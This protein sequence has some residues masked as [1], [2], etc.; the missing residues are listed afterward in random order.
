MKEL[1]K[2]KEIDMR[3]I[4][5]HEQYD[6]SPWIE[7]NIYKI[8]ELLNLQIEIEKREESIEKFRL[9]LSGIESYSQVPVVIENQYN[10]SDHAHLG[11]LITYSAHKEAGI[12]IWI[13]NQFHKAHINAINWLNT[14]SPEEMLF[15]AVQLKVIQI[16]N[17]K[18]APLFNIAV[19]PPSY[20]MRLYES[21]ELSDRQKGYLSFFENLKEKINQTYPNIQVYKP[22]PRNYIHINIGKNI[23]SG[24]HI[25]VSFGRGNIFRVEIYID[26]GN[27]EDNDGLFTELFNSKDEIEE[28]LGAILEWDN[29]P[30]RRACRISLNMEGSIDDSEEKL[31]ELH[32]FATNNII[33]FQKVFESFTQR[34]ELE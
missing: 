8:N 22:I 19:K 5:P 6:F 33:K 24:V 32:K 30:N 27:K 15:F 3:K 28:N 16:D 11:K 17:S 2:I 4:W 25:S 12:I 34:F 21:G 26:T 20:K 1:G 14:I 31:K 29:L 9:D 10:T 7:K 23:I 13:A 18:L